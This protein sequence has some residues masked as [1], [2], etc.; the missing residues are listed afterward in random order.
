M[1]AVSVP[2]FSTSWTVDPRRDTVVVV[3]VVDP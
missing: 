2:R 1:V 3:V